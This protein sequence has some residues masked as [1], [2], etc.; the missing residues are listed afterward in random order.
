MHFHRSVIYLFDT[1]SDISRYPIPLAYVIDYRSSYPNGSKSVKLHLTGIIIPVN[2]VYK[3][4]NSLISH[5]LNVLAFIANGAHFLDIASNN[6]QIFG[7]DSVP[8]RYILCLCVFRPR[9]FSDGVNIV[10][11]KVHSHAL[12]IT[13]VNEIVPTA[14]TFVSELISLKDKTIV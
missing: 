7:K 1:L 13:H 6:I 12:F 4:K 3:L 5:I 9:F 11:I 2:T 14:C 10:F 8:E